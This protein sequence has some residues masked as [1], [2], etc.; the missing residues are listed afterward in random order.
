LLDRY[1][2]LRARG[3]SVAVDVLCRDTPELLAD[4]QREIAAAE[5]LGATARVNG[6]AKTRRATSDRL[7]AF[8]GS[9]GPVEGYELLEELGRGGVGVVFK[10][11]QVSL[12]RV[13]ALKLVRADGF[14]GPESRERFLAEAAVVARMQ[15]P[16]IVHIYECSAHDEQMY[17]SMELCEGGSLAQ[18]LRMGP[19][20]PREAAA[21][22]R[23]VAEGVQAAHDQ[24]VIH[25][26]LSPGNILLARPGRKPPEG[27]P[28]DGG[29]RPLAEF[30]P[31]VSDF[32]LAKRI[33]TDV[34]RSGAFMGTPRYMAPEQTL[35]ARAVDHRADVYALGA[36]LYECLTGR[37]PFHAA[38][39]IETLDQVRHQEPVSL[40]QF[41]SS[42]PRDL[43]TICLKCLNKEPA[44][45]YSSARELAD[46]LGRFLDGEPI[47]AR[48]TR[49]HERFARWCQRAARVPFAGRLAVALYGSL[50]VWKVLALVLVA[51]GVG[52]VPRDPRQCVFQVLALLAFL[53]VPQI[54][55]GFATLARR[56][57]APW[58]GSILSLI[59]LVLVSVCL[60][61]SYFTFGGLL[62]EPDIR[63]L[64]LGLL[65]IL[66]GVTLLAYLAAIIA[67]RAGRQGIR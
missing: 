44:K 53:N 26:D 1:L 4:L 9:P 50:A 22:M 7:T 49:L 19:L 67:Q 41:Q 20:A 5:Q 45:R 48:P 14:Q 54:A 25:R 28:L 31:K 60:P 8:P 24:G 57:S 42:V 32:G 6:L 51:L 11:Q 12:N 33:D 47:R 55:I 2:D 40:R 38:N 52:L 29:P 16:N 23:S 62:E 66:E 46:D 58:I 10:A 39:L 21:L 13:V 27:T 34:T 61:T 36:I 35:D 56:R 3:Q 63:W 64:V 18:R 65:I 17:F 59:H 37:P 43:D 30:I 15:H